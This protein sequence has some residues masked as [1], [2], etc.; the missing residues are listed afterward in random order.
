MKADRSC[1]GIAAVA[2]LI[3]LFTAPAKA[4]ADTY[5]IYLLVGAN[6]SNTFL[7]APIGITDSGTVVVSVDPVNCNG[8]PGH[9]YETFD[10][11]VLVSQSLTN[12]SLAYDNGTPCTPNAS[13]NG[14]FSAS[15]CN[16]GREVYGTAI[17]SAQYPLSIF[18]GPDPAA[19]FF[20]NGLLATV[21][22][23]SSGDF[24]YWVN[25]AGSSSGEIYE[26]VDLTTSEVPEPSSIVLLGIGLFAAAGTMRRRLFHL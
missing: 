22:L 8:T 12:P 5:Q 6:N 14:S 2:V 3:G 17:N 24:L 1:L 7:T 15:V 21:D 26:A 9:C 23:N 10:S 20:A 13:F 4:H 25:A 11:G 16:N 19:D 18:T